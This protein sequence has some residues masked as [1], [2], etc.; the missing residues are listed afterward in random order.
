MLKKNKEIVMRRIIILINNV[1]QKR[2]FLNLVENDRKS[3]D[4]VSSVRTNTREN[5]VNHG[6]SDSHVSLSSNV[7]ILNKIEDMNSSLKILEE[8]QN[9]FGKTSDRKSSFDQQVSKPHLNQYQLYRST[10][11]KWS[12]NSET[13]KESTD[14]ESEWSKFLFE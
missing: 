2:V 1:N 11:Q 6:I 13:V 7:A 9:T 8:A 10:M 3:K 14:Q 4:S 5:S 12:I